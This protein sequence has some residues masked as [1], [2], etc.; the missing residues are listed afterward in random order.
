MAAGAQATAATGKGLSNEQILEVLIKRIEAD[1]SEAEEAKPEDEKLDDKNT[2][3]KK[4]DEKVE[5]E[6][7][8][9]ESAGEGPVVSKPALIS[10]T[11]PKGNEV[12]VVY[13]STYS[14]CGVRDDEADPE[15]P[16]IIFLTRYDLKT[17]T[18]IEVADIAGDI[19]WTV[20]SNGVFTRSVL[21]EEGENKFAIAACTASI[22][23]AAKTEGR[24]IEDHEIQIVRF[25]I[26]YRAQNVAEK[27][28]EIFKELTIAN[29]LKEIENH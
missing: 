8:A 9:D 4:P 27:I 6:K 22:I 18:F 26:I 19:Q 12:E 13:K 2:A 15:E 21:L 10:V 1:I 14:I 17:E 5:S 28:S 24:I 23:E 3:E 11:N 20:G 29:I 7:K 16:I 25:N